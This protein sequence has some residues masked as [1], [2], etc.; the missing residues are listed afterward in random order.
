MI[1]PAVSVRLDD[2]R[3]HY[4]PGDILSG[5]IRI[6][7]LQP[8]QIR[9]VELSVVWCTEGKGEEDVGLHFFKRYSPEE[10]PLDPRSAIRFAA[11]PLPASP[12]SYEGL[13]VKI[14]WC[15]RVRLFLPHG[16]TL[17]HDEPFQLGDVPQARLPE[18]EP[19]PESTLL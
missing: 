2:R 9:A 1:Q 11:E 12:L 14:R 5:E 15:V 10:E 3:R 19:A 8:D 4:R 16:E 6:E 17:V 18:P 13:I 7:T